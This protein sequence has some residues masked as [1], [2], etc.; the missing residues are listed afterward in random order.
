M[1]VRRCGAAC[2][3]IAAGLAIGA[4]AASGHRAPCHTKHTC[5]SDH[6]TYT[7]QKLWCTSFR[8]ERLV[9]DTKT[10][11]VGGH[12]YWCGARKTGKKR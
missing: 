8:D 2:V 9:S 7:Y 6:H 10:L 4:P 11:K 12:T 1:Q 5:P 3:V